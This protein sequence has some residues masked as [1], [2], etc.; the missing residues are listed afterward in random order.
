MLAMAA[1]TASWAASARAVLWV[2]GMGSAATSIRP[3]AVVMSRGP[4]AVLRRRE[5]CDMPTAVPPVM[6]LNS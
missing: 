2:A 6:I 1:S 3:R 4:V 5:K